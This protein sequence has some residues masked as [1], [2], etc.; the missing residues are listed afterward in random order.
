MATLA[1]LACL[2]GRHPFHELAA[3]RFDGEPVRS[4]VEVCPRCG[5]ERVNELKL[6]FLNLELHALVASSG[7]SYTRLTPE[8]TDWLDRRP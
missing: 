4:G 7:E 6:A 2:L 8:L 1:A 5:Q 3:V